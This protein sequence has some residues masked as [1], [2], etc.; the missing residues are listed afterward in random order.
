MI[1]TLGFVV[2]WLA[3]SSAAVA[4]AWTGVAI[5]D[6]EIISPAPAVTDDVAAPGSTE[7]GSSLDAAATGRRAAV[8]EPVDLDG[9]G[10]T[11]SATVG[12]I[13]PGEQDPPSR[14]EDEAGGSGGQG[15]RSSGSDS[16]GSP[17]A[18]TDRGNPTSARSGASTGSTV[19]RG[20]APTT[21]STP[22]PIGPTTRSTATTPTTARPTTRPTTARATAPPTTSAPTAPTAPS[23]AGPT[24]VQPTTQ[25]PPTTSP[26]TTSPPTSAPPTTQSSQTISYHLVGGSTAI[27]F[28]PSEVRVL[29][30]TPNPGFDVDVDSDRVEFEADH[31]RSRLDFWWSGG[32]RDEIREQDRS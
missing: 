32:P 15:S 21:R 25:P 3:G 30:A 4:V 16:D 1:K 27:S 14:V 29:W 12:G 19:S 17:S 10:D 24:T 13:R 22:G 20:S 9:F 23:T 7:R 6:D 5:V 26:P 18:T 11:T 31:H 2:L 8:D 28:S